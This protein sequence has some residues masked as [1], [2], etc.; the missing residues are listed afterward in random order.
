MPVTGESQQTARTG[1]IRSGAGEAIGAVVAR[2]SG[3]GAGLTGQRAMPSPKT[4]LSSDGGG[5]FRGKAM[6][7]R[8]VLFAAA[9]LRDAGASIMLATGRA[10][11]S[12]GRID[13]SIATA[14]K[15]RARAAKVTTSREGGRIAACITTASAAA[16]GI[17]SAIRG[18]IL[19]EAASGN[20][21]GEDRTTSVG[22]QGL[23][24]IHLVGLRA[25]IM[26]GGRLSEQ[27]LV[28]PVGRRGRGYSSARTRIGLVFRA[29]CA[30]GP[31]AVT[32]G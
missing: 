26:S 15:G 18:E 23:A 22:Q 31:T 11:R 28:L 30:S 4:A 3:H 20:A 17:G 19:Q 16:T 5:P 14:V 12:G 1:L 24:I 7:G 9:G 21:S 32:H 2:Q 6:L 29:S 27:G 10:A 13:P 25:A 8:R